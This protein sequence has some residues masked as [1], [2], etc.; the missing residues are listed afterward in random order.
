MTSYLLDTH[1]VIWLACSPKRVP[2]DILTQLADPQ[3][4]RLVSAVTAMEITTK[5]R[6]GKL[7]EGELFV[8]DW[9][10]TL[11]RLM[12]TQIS[13]TPAQGHAAGSL[14]WDH[15]DQFDRMLAAQAIDLGVPLVSADACMATLPGLDVRWG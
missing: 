5:Y 10:G 3:N 8:Q 1:V 12:A 4:R 6:L 14:E 13:L 9:D 7:P 2:E 15:R 11:D